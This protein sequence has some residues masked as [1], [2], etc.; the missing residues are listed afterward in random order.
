M[1]ENSTSKARTTSLPTAADRAQAPRWVRIEQ[2][3]SAWRRRELLVRAVPAAS[4]RDAA[5]RLDEQACQETNHKLPERA[6]AVNI[7]YVGYKANPNLPDGGDANNKVPHGSSKNVKAPDSS[8]ENDPTTNN[9][10]EN[11]PAPD[12][13]SENDAARIAAARTTRPWTAAARATWSR[14]AA[15]RTRGCG[16]KE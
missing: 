9:S 1:N 10:S 11:D 16:L 7:L 2:L 13:S 12:N 5:A 6:S 3:A 8:S 4:S 15:A 14:T